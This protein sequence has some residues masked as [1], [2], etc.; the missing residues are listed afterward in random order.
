MGRPSDLPERLL[1]AMLLMALYSIRSERQLAERIDTDSLFAMIQLPRKTRQD[2]R[3]SNL[4][5]VSL[6]AFRGNF[7]FDYIHFNP[8]EA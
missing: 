3:R 8:V 7:L 5:F 4:F 6:C 2:T 1:K